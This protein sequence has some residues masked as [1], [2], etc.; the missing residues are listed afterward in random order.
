MDLNATQ[1]YIRAGY[2]ASLE[3]A[4]VE[5]HKLLRKPN[6]Q[7]YI[8]QLKQQRSQRTEI[9][10]DRVLAEF[11]AIGFTRI[12]DVISFDENSVTVKN[13][14][15]LNDDMAAAI[16]EVSLTESGKVKRTSV[17]MHDKIQ[18]LK[19]IAEHLGMFN[20]F[21]GAIRT[22]ANKYGLALRQQEDGNWVVENRRVPTDSTNIT[23]ENPAAN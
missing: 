2:S 13:S 10:A 23:A 5:A 4:A 15:H 7:L 11:A 20:D 17:K 6:I 22:L 3:V 1:A 19:A 21:E 14:S 8:T 18:A 12:T 9:T 16:A